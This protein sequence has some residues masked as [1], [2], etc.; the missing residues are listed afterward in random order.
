MI[1]NLNQIN[2]KITSLIENSKSDQEILIW[3]Q[4][5]NR[6]NKIKLMASKLLSKNN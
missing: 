4:L 5:L 3:L 6:L 1:A 2:K